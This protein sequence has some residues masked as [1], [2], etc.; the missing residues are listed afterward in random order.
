M[1][2]PIKDSADFFLKDYGSTLFPLKMNRLL[3]EKYAKQLRDFIQEHVLA[4][5]GAFQN[6]HRVFASKRGW[7]LR[8][9]VKLD[10][11]AEFFLY[12]IIYRNR[13]CFRPSP[14]RSR[15]VHGFRISRGEPLS[16]LKEYVQFKKSVARHRNAYKGYAYL[17]IASYFNHIYHHDLVRWFEDVGASQDDVNAFGKF[18]REIVGERS[19][20][21]LPQGLYPAKMVGAAFLSFLE[22]SNRIRAAQSVRLMD[23]IWLFD[24]DQRT[25]VSD[26]LVIQ[27]LL[28]DRGL[29]ISD[30]KSA[31]LDGYDP[32]SELPA[33]LNDMKIHL[34]RK[35]REE[36]RHTSFYGD[37]F[38]DEE[39]DENEQHEDPDDLDELGEDEQEYLV[40]LLRSDTIHEEDAELVLTLM[41][42]NSADVMEFLPILTWVPKPGE[43]D[44][45]LLQ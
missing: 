17:D 22:D 29:T 40:S 5:E 42:E 25:L 15:E 16:A 36:L 37:P 11:I 20:D 9:T 30:K 14:N 44:L 33:D 39:D 8:R 45:P 10:P 4:G 32:N 28:S 13:T 19:V 24:N 27:A 43:K 7:F 18:L 2:T 35:R 6:Q 41:H 26:F 21:C 12:D 3:V 1:T 38:E 31:I 34:L 23:D